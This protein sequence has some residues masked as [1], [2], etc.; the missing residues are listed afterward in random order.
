MTAVLAAYSSNRWRAI[1]LD[2]ILV[3]VFAVI[4]RANHG[5]TL[6]LWG[7][8]DTAWPFVIACLLGW[9]VVTLARLPHARAWPSG[10]V[11]WVVTVA[12]GMGLR[13]LTGDTAATAFVIV[14]SVTLAVFLIAPRLLLR[15]RRFERDTASVARSPRA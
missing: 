5:E 3:V 8:A 1:A 15:R 4:G 7:V 13:I 10:L 9:L 14:A 2:L 12:A 11:I 6:T